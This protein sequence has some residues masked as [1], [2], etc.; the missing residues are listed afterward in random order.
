M[1][2]PKH[3]WFTSEYAQLTSR[4]LGLQRTDGILKEEEAI[5]GCPG[6][7]MCWDCNMGGCQACEYG[8]PHMKTRSCSKYYDDIMDEFNVG[9]GEL[10]LRRFNFIMSRYLGLDPGGY[11]KETKP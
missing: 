6:C 5:Y 1:R 4:M 2:I 3:D 7:G 10:E 9:L 8:V 11:S